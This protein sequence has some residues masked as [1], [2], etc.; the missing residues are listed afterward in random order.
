MGMFDGKEVCLEVGGGVMMALAWQ[1]QGG[2]NSPERVAANSFACQNLPEST[3]RQVSHSPAY[4]PV[5]MHT[6]C[7]PRVG[8]PESW[9]V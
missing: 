5:S 8:Q 4:A 3:S 9:I 2:R 6:A 1:H 7:A